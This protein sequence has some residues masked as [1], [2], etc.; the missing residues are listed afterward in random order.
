MFRFRHPS[1]HL[2]V[3]FDVSM[4]LYFHVSIYLVICLSIYLS[5]YLSIVLSIFLSMAAVLLSIHV[6][7]NRSADLTIYLLISTYR[8]AHRC[9]YVYIMFRLI[10]YSHIYV[11][12]CVHRSIDRSMYACRI[13]TRICA[14][15]MLSIYRSTR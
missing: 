5:I 6:L 12:I 2:Y 14:S 1:F 10:H 4:Y 8:H 13:Y 9:V 15:F 3:Y 11:Y 7:I